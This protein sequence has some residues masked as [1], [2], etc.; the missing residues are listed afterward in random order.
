MNNEILTFSAPMRLSL[1]GGGSDLPE[2]Y[3]KADTK[4]MSVSINER[5]TIKVGKNI[6]N[7][8]SQLVEIF[9]QKHPYCNVQVSS[10]IPP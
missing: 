4:V 10:N 3:L 6:E 7:T 9:Q 1:A 2:S 5:V 8:S